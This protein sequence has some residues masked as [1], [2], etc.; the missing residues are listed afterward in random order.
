MTTSPGFSSRPSIHIV[1]QLSQRDEAA[2]SNPEPGFS[3]SKSAKSDE[4]APVEEKVV[5]AETVEDKV[6]SRK[7]TARKRPAKKS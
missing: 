3:N 1:R 6:V 4:P 5:A 7:A 2:M